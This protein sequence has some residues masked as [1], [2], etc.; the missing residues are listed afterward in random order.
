MR[1]GGGGGGGGRGAY[2]HN[3]IDRPIT[4]GGLLAEGL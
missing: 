1:G 4:G 3:T 2:N